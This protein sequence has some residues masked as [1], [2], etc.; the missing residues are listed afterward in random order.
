[1]QT[2]KSELK[3]FYHSLSVIL[4]IIIAGMVLFYWKDLPD[5]IPI[6]FNFEGTPDGWA[7]KENLLILFAVALGVNGLFYLIT[8]STSWL[9]KHP[10]LLNIPNK[11]RFLALPEEKQ[12]VYW[13]LTKE[14]TAGMMA[15]I[16]IL[17]TTLMW[18]T[19]RVCLGKLNKLPGWAIYPGLG[20]LL[21]VVIMYAPRLILMPKKLIKK[22]EQR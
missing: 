20:I 6:H 2:E 15:S 18:G 16:N 8:L 14:F 4:L 21:I 9:S 19:I 11:E 10:S 12:Q 17:W 22:Q 7:G 5:K 13:E 3:R 1:M